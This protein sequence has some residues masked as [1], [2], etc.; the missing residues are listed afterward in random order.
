M[1]SSMRFPPFPV[2]LAREKLLLSYCGSRAFHAGNPLSAPLRGLLRPGMRN[3]APQNRGVRGTGNL[4]KKHIC[5][6]VAHA[7]CHPGDAERAVMR[8]SHMSRLLR[9]AYPSPVGAERGSSVRARPLQILGLKTPISRGFAAA[10]R[11]RAEEARCIRT[12]WPPSGRRRMRVNRL[13]GHVCQR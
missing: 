8:L 4:C 1:H 6:A 10:Q 13:S 5:G 11:T 7:V 12:D 3:A 9:M 2:L